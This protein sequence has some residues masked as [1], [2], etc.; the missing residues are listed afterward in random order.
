MTE[1]YI[2]QACKD[3]DREGQFALVRRYSGVLLTICKRYSPDG[4]VAQDILQESF[5]LIFRNIDKYKRIGSFEGWMRK[6]TVRCALSW[7]KKHQRHYR[8]SL[9]NLD[10]LNT[11]HPIIYS[12][13]SESEI[14]HQI[15][16]LPEGYR[17]VF[18]LYIIDG[19][20][21][22]EIAEMLEIKESASR[23]QLT[24]ARKLLKEQISRQGFIK[25]Y[26]H[27]LG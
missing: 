23:S 9:I 18:N 17:T 14:L 2:I 15:S 6:I 8:N 24:R 1:E 13:M 20:S 25:G 27:E 12:Q 5:I 4:Q 26:N 11:T 22:K 10:N 19:Y 21:H 3:R 16:L 7:I